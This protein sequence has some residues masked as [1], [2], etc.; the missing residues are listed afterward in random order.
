MPDN[1]LVGSVPLEFLQDKQINS[2][3][4]RWMNFIVVIEI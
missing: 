4:F 3:I 2:R 1:L